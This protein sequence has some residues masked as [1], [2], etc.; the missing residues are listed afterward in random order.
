M[1]TKNDFGQRKESRG[2][3]IKIVFVFV[4]PATGIWTEMLLKSLVQSTRIRSLSIL[5]LHAKYSPPVFL[6]SRHFC[7]QHPI[8]A[9]TIPSTDDPEPLNDHENPYV[10]SLFFLLI[11]R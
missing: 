3:K 7:I 9:T 5:G 8:S 10:I 1:K 6:C 11:F 4:V 2:E